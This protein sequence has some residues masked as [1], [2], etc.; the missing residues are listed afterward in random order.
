[1]ITRLQAP[2]GTL[3]LTDRGAFSIQLRLAYILCYFIRKAALVLGFYSG[4]TRDEYHVI[5]VDFIVALRRTRGQRRWTLRESLSSIL[6]TLT[7]HPGG[8]AAAGHICCRGFGA[9]LVSVF[10]CKSLIPSSECCAAICVRAWTVRVSV[11]FVGH[12]S[13]VFHYWGEGLFV[14]AATWGFCQNLS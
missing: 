14:P 6:W 12:M 7:P 3:L 9:I 1:M 13:F 11:D 4:F 10:R 2:Q 5:R 8:S